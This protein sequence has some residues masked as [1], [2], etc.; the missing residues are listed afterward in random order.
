M[1][2]HDGDILMVDRRRWWYLKSPKVGSLAYYFRYYSQ[3]AY[4]PITKA[5]A[6]PTKVLITILV[7]ALRCRDLMNFRHCV[8]RDVL[9][10]CLCFFSA[11]SADVVAKYCSGTFRAHVLPRANAGIVVQGAT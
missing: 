4:Q 3:L 2:I 1:E 6:R 8:P 11:P 9:T 5:L 7:A 10:M